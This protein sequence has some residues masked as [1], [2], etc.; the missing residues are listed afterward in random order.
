MLLQLLTSDSGG[1][2]HLSPDDDR[3]QQWFK[4]QIEKADSGIYQCVAHSDAGV[5][6]DVIVVEVQAP[7]ELT[8]SFKNFNL[9]FF[10]EWSI[11]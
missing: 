8:S 2:V 10:S 3:T 11:F 9:F 6:S 5:A 4:S 1:S 7:R